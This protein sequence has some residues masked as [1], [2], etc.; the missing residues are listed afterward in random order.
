MGEV[1]T[2]GHQ[3]QATG[4]R[5][6]GANHGVTEQTVADRILEALEWHPDCSMEELAELCSDLTWD[7]IFLTVD[8]MSR[9]GQIILRLLGRGVY[10]VRIP[11][12]AR[13][14]N[15]QQDIA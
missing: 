11:Q 12:L 7:E 5:K 4:R 1:P 3:P 6:K 14:M 13:P 10:A 8:Q 15:R 9:T 2:S